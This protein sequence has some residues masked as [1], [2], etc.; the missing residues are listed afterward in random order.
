MA[1]ETE[2]RLHAHLH[3]WRIVARIV[4]PVR[5]ARRRGKFARGQPVQPLAA[6]PV[7]LAEQGIDQ[8][9]FG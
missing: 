1:F 2:E 8:F 7:E 9:T 5:G 6:V 4:D 3:A